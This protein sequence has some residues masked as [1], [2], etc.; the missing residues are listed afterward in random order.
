MCVCIHSL[1][2]LA[3]CPILRS[4]F[5]AVGPGD[6]LDRRGQSAEEARDESEAQAPPRTEHG[7]AVAVADVVGESVQVPRVAGQLKV[8]SSHARAQWNDAEGSWRKEGRG[9]GGTEK[10]TNKEKLEKW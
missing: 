9:E 3:H 8:D 5:G 4:R 6:R 10:K 1:F 7:P 2:V